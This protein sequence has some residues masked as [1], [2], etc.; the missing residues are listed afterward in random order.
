[1]DSRKEHGRGRRRPDPLAGIFDPEVVPMLTES[2]GLRAVAV[3]KELRRHHPDLPL[4]VRRTLDVVSRH[5]ARHRARR[6]RTCAA[7]AAAGEAHQP[8]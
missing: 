2:P 7:V 4:A 6:R 8:L 3:F 5:N 1:M